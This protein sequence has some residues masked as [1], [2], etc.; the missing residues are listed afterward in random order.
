MGHFSLI[1]C[2]GYQR[3]DEHPGRPRL[4]LHYIIRVTRVTQARQP[5]RQPRRGSQEGKPVSASIYATLSRVP[6][7]R[8][9]SLSS[10]QRTRNDV[11]QL[12]LSESHIQ[13]AR[14]VRTESSPA[15]GTASPW[16]VP[17]LRMSST[18]SSFSSRPISAQ[19]PLAADVWVDI[20]G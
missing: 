20:P 10:A 8:P 4:T 3:F 19:C 16:G 17:A 7:G 9:G 2:L 5:R 6:F 14:A 1:D 15:H 12:E 13:Q 11:D 18:L